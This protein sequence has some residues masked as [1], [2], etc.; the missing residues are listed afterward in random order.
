MRLVLTANALAGDLDLAARDL[1]RP[2]ATLRKDLADLR[3]L[4]AARTVALF[5]PAKLGLPFRCIGL[6]RL[7][8]H[9]PGQIQAFEDLCLKDEAVFRAVQLCGPYDYQLLT[10]H[11]DH[12]AAE[13]WRRMVEAKELVGV[14]KLRQVRVLKGHDLDGLPLTL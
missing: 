6:V 9:T 5:D 4:G 3:R 2:R 8:S 11:A 14:L 7:R 13:S 1:G 10:M 12:R